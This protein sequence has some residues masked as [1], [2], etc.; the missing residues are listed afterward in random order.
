MELGYTI[1]K[2]LGLDD[3]ADQIRE[4]MMYNQLMGK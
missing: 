3:A 4:G 2:A 1:L